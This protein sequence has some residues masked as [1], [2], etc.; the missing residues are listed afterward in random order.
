MILLHYNLLKKVVSVKKIG[1]NQIMNTI[2]LFK[3]GTAQEP[4]VET[5]TIP[6][7]IPNATAAAQ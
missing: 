2:T 5:V 1:S 7:S 4:T 3:D 6:D